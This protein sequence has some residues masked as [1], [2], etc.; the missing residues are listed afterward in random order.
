MRVFKYAEE[1]RRE[2]FLE[3]IRWIDDAKAVL[4]WNGTTKEFAIVR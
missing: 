1:A 4:V 2:G 3:T